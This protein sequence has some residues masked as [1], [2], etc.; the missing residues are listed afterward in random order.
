MSLHR[1]WPNWAL[2][3]CSDVITRQELSR[4]A[5]KSAA[6]LL[7]PEYNTSTWLSDPM[8][9]W[10]YSWSGLPSSWHKTCKFYSIF[11]FF[12]PD[13]IVP[14]WFS[15]LYA[16]CLHVQSQYLKQ[17]CL[18]YLT[19]FIFLSIDSWHKQ[20]CSFNLFFTYNLTLIQ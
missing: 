6:W 18:K 16:I 8:G 13:L 14:L 3:L 1:L 11:F 2:Q 20:L 19:E 7:F 5:T 12:L 4:T 9:H 17:Y 10:I 15:T